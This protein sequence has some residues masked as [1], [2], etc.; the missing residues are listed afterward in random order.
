M[1]CV[2]CVCCFTLAIYYQRSGV[3]D[4]CLYSL[5][6]SFNSLHFL[7]ASFRRICNFIKK[8]TLA[9]GVF[10]YR[11][12]LVAASEWL[13]Q[14]CFHLSLLWGAWFTIPRKNSDRWILGQLV[15]YFQTYSSLLYVPIN[16]LDN[17]VVINVLRFF[18]Y[19][20]SF[21]LCVHL[22]FSTPQS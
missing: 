13:E 1:L 6:F 7:I 9:P 2:W 20:L 22:I 8:E 21:A 16:F 4:V 10:L 14:Y 18:L 3:F 19:F 17:T 12:P 15:E 11:T 5:I